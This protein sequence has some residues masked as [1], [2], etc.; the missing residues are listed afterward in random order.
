MKIPCFS[1]LTFICNKTQRHTHTRARAYTCMLSKTKVFILQLG[2][3]L[4]S[5]LAEGTQ[6]K[7]HKN[8]HR[9]RQLHQ[10]QAADSNVFNEKWKQNGDDIG[11]I[12][13]L[14]MTKMKE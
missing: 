6:R 9:E 11:F 4:S 14:Q 5:N 7:P 13:K 1:Q 3:K 8:T 12:F 2:E 10:L